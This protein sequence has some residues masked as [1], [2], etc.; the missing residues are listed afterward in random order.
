MNTLSTRLFTSDL[1]YWWSN[2]LNVDRCIAIEYELKVTGE[3]IEGYEAERNKC[4]G[5]KVNL[6]LCLT[7]FTLLHEGV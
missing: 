4:E 5:S 6:S 1:Y 7:N 2:K 3:Q